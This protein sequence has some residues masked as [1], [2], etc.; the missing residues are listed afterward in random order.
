MPAAS[1]T[2]KW[3]VSPPPQRSDEALVDP[4]PTRLPV[5]SEQIQYLTLT[6]E[7]SDEPTSRIQVTVTLE[8]GQPPV[9]RRRDSYPL[10]EFGLFARMARRDFMIDCVRHPVIRKRADDTLV[11]TVRLIF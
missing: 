8:P 7:P 10:R 3:V 1:A 11:R 2:E 6:G 4:R 5:S 9:P